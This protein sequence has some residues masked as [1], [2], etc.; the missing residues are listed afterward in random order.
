M[1]KEKKQIITSN[2]PSPAGPYSQA[3]IAGDFVFVAGQRPQNPVNGFISDN[4]Q[5]QTKQCIKNIEAILTEAGSS[6]NQIVRSDV[7]LS[8]IKNFDAMNKIYSAMMPK[9]FPSRTTIG[10]NLRN[11]LIEIEVIALRGDSK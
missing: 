1:N 5:D 4:I 11:I 3:I 9:P 10:V 2:A 8:D 6:L 7:Y